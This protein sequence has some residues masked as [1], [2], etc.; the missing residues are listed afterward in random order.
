VSSE[1]LSQY[2]IQLLLLRSGA[3]SLCNVLRVRVKRVQAMTVRWRVKLCNTG[4][5]SY[6]FY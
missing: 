2:G 1:C 6:Y 5:W 4:R 3:H